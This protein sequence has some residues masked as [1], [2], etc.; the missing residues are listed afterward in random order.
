MLSKEGLI[1][2]GEIF[3]KYKIKNNEI[4]FVNYDVD[5]DDG[6]CNHNGDD[7]NGLV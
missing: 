2:T 1:F 4:C 3:I 5:D 6:G 7:N